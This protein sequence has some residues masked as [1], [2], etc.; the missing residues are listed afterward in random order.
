M[1]FRKGGACRIDVES[2]AA[3]PGLGSLIWFVTPRMLRLAG[4]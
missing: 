1:P 2:L 4:R 3:R